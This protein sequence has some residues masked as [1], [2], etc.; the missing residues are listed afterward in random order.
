MRVACPH[1]QASYNVDDR[2]IPVSGLNVRCPKCQNTF[3][4]RKA[5]EGSGVASTA[6]P[7]PAPAPAWKAEARGAVPL[8]APEAAAIPSPPAPPPSA[9][10]IAPPPRRAAGLDLAADGPAVPLPEPSGDGHPPAPPPQEP[11]GFG[12]VSL[13]SPEAPSP[14]PPRQ[15]EAEEVVSFAEP[16]PAEEARPPA[17][18]GPGALGPAEEEELEMLFGEGSDSGPT[19]V[20][21][22]EPPATAAPRRGGYKVR[23]RSGKVFGPFEAAQ[24]VEMLG[25]GELLGNEEVSSD[26]GKTWAGVGSVPAFA[27]SLRKLSE[28]PAT[29]E[30]ARSKRIPAHFAGR[31]APGKVAERVERPGR[32]F[33]PL[34]VAGGVLVVALG[35]GLAGGLT[36]HGLFFHNLLRGRR[37][38]SGPAAELVRRSRAAL[39][40]DRFD[41]AAQALDLAEQALRL[42]GDDPEARSAHVQAAAWLAPRGGAPEAVLARA[43]QELA[44]LEKQEAD[45]RATLEAAL[46]FSVDAAPERRAAASAAMARMAAKGP[47]QAGQLFLLAEAA[48]ASGDAAGA[49]EW[50]AKL[51]AV[52]PGSPRGNHL[53]GLL[54]ARK[55]E[56]KAASALFV[57]A[58]DKDPRHASSALELATLVDRGV[59][60]SRAEALLRGLLAPE[61]APRLGPAERARAHAQL[62]DLVLRHG[63]PDEARYREAEREF[64]EALREDPTGVPARLAY[65]RY[66][67]KRGAAERAVQALAPVAGASARDAELFALNARALVLAGRALDAKNA[68]DAALAKSPQS[69]PLVFLKGFVVEQL[70]KPDEARALYEKA[71]A[72]DPSDFAP[73]LGLGRLALESGDLARAGAEIGLAVEKGPRQPDARAVL[74]D[75]KIARRDAAGAEAAYREAL[76]LDPDHARAHA[77]LARVA[78]ER[79]D[80]A[81]AR[82][83]LERA[84][85]LDPRLGEAQVSLGMLLWKAGDPEGAKKAFQA[86][87]ALDPRGAVA[88]TRLGAVELEQKQLEA[89]LKDLGQATDA[90][91]GSA[92]AQFWYGRALLARNDTGQAVERLKRAVDLDPQNAL[93]HLHLGI[94]REQAGALPEARDA[95]LAAVARDPRL[96]EGWER[97]GLLLV[98]QGLFAEAVPN[99][100]K[101]LSTSPRNQR[102]RVAIGDCKE[103]LGKHAEA[104]RAYREALKGDPSQV[105]LYYRIARAI[106]EGFGAREAL[107]WY[108]RAA[109]EDRKNAMPH[110]YLGHAYKERRQRSRAIQEFRAYLK[111]RP[112]ADDRKDIEQEIEDLGG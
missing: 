29:P 109:R 78:L 48:A 106:H 80:S 20:T 2:R 63:G 90:D 103:R 25:K 62:A 27:D 100:E 50:L 68:V 98:S 4:V 107:P 7:L 87:V 83:E 56:G 11:L 18:A 8:P 44:G 42:D 38:A 34:A 69:E 32:R 53:R 39:A 57:K 21:V 5:A 93:H 12:E 52:E 23:R 17:A 30:P 88:R 97:L 13:E 75:W 77:G 19:A 6:V 46:A 65:A 73:H 59:D 66:F 81:G 40:E 72:Q 41:A 67:M 92:E 95:Y 79:G 85:A 22:S 55:G 33:I 101:A 60:P 15:A 37:A 3:P 91:P 96:T 10:V 102:F 112:D 47:A 45:E 43:R 84:L 76:S 111:L 24:I 54:A 99:F 61:A 28:P 31:M 71:A 49:G 9:P 58:M 104:I 105:G 89:A 35:A 110:Y 36:R 70:G 82:R 16:K 26:G 14:I 1:C 64:E 51:D 94:A 108:E 74:G 86:A